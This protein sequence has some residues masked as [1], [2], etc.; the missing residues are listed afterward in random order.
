VPLLLQLALDFA[1]MTVP[2]SNNAYSEINIPTSAL[3][4]INKNSRT[5]FR[6][7][8]NTLADFASDVLEIYGGE[9]STY[10]PQLF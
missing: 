8:A 2:S 9:S 4:F 3:E 1:T 10:A 6:L 5:Q 7:K